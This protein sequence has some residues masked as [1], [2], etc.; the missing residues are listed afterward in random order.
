[1][2]SL[3][4][5]AQEPPLVA[6]EPETPVDPW[7]CDGCPHASACAKRQLAC[8]AYEKYLDGQS[9]SAAA[10]SPT[11]EWWQALFAP[12]KRKQG[13]TTQELI[14]LAQQ[15]VPHMIT[16]SGCQKLF[17]ISQAT[18]WKWEKT[19]RLPPRD[20]FAEGIGVGWR[21]ETLAAAGARRKAGAY[22][23]RRAAITPPSVGRCGASAPAPRPD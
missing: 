7:P 17:D 21:P 23:R 10:R 11:R 12:A 20:V 15:Q 4:A 22:K 1:M 16:A 3:P 13:N 8:A 19:G 5:D 14:R 6:S 18:R 9:W 2:R